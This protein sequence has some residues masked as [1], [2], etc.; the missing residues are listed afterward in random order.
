V[1][2][3][4]L[5]FAR[6]VVTRSPVYMC[7]QR[8]LCCEWRPASCG[9]GPGRSGSRRTPAQVRFVTSRSFCLLRLSHLVSTNRASG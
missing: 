3:T 5:R 4:D 6:F 8:A 9:W 1:C 2:P 7:A